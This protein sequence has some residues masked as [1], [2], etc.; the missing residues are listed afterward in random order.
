MNVKKWES[1]EREITSRLVSVKIKTCGK[2][3]E[4][5]SLRAKKTTPYSFQS[6]Q[7]FPKYIYSYY[8]DGNPNVINSKQTKLDIAFA[9]S[10]WM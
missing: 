3:H 9:V 7:K 4:P 6:S 8:S 5:I 2:K 1:L 10:F